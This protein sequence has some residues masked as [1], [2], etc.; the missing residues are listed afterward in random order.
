MD[1]FRETELATQKR[2]R[3]RPGTLALKEIRRFQKTTDLLIRKMPFAR[4]VRVMRR[5]T[6]RYFAN[7]LFQRGVSPIQ[8]AGRLF[9][10]TLAFKFEHRVFVL[11]AAAA[12]TFPLTG[13]GDFQRAL[14]RTAQIHGGEF[15]SVTGGDGRLF[16]TPFRGLQLVRHSRQARHNHAQGFT[17]RSSHQ[18]SNLRRRR[19]LGWSMD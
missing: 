10:D 11:T 5:N 14:T 2:R 16:G 17:T 18:R 7:T 3:Y 8:S 13:S 6:D 9:L 1:A 4:L 12:F 19:V 15:I